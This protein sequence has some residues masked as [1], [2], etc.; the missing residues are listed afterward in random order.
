MLLKQEEK[1]K[2]EKKQPLKAGKGKPAGGGGAACRRCLV[3]ATA[4]VHRC[5]P[6]PEGCDDL[7]EFEE[8]VEE[9]YRVRGSQWFD[10][11]LNRIACLV[12]LLPLRDVN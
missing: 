3:A 1:L 4:R 9:Y 8:W 7:D 12:S 6:C 5:R 11:L 2:S 10:L